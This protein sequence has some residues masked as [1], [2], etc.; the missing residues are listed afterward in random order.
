MSWKVA[1]MGAAGKM[2]QEVAKAVLDAE[3]MILIGAVD[4][5]VCGGDLKDLL[6]KGPS[7]SICSNLE[8]LIKNPDRLPDTIVDFTR[9]ECVFNNVKTAIEN[10]I[11]AV[12]GTTGLSQ[13]AW[14]ELDELAL[15]HGVGVF[16]APNFSLGAVLMMRFAQEAIR[17]FPKAEIIEMHHDQKLD[18]PSGTSLYTA[19][20]IN[21]VTDKA[22]A[23]QS[24]ITDD[25]VARGYKE[26]EIHIHSV[27]LPG[28]IAH[29][30]VIF[31]LPGQILTIR[32]DSTSRESFMP[33][34]L[35]AIRKVSQFKGVII[36]LDHLM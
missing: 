4:P 35:L 10:K 24:G 12:V 6:A 14:N 7:L 25:S 30:E 2:G 5:A 13:D 20:L 23:K 15:K 33:G 17:Y 31:G 29:Q 21:Q 16:H 3:D 36:G 34:V 1:V 19:D 32:H 9:P 18:S 27:R 8:D 26:K 28:F 11:N 22:I